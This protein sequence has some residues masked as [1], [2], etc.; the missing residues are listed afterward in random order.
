MSMQSTILWG[1]GG[2]AVLLLAAACAPSAVM[3]PDSNTGSDASEVAWKDGQKAYAIS[4]AVPQ[5]CNQRA[6]TVCNQ[7]AYKV[8][9]SENMPSA[10]DVLAVKGKPAIVIRCG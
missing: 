3:G 6:I 2:L 10:G 9:N 1:T 7:G 4:C 8:L 5:G